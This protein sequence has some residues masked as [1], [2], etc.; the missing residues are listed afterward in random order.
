MKRSTASQASAT[1]PRTPSGVRRG[2]GL[3]T[4]LLAATTGLAACSTGAAGPPSDAQTDKLEVISWWTSGSEHPALQSLFDAFTAANPGVTITDGAVAGGGGSNVAVVLA[5]RLTAG[6]PPD[7]WQT[8]IGASTK[9]YANTGRIADVSSVYA[10]TGLAGAIPKAILDSV[11][12]GGKQYSVPSGSHRS[13]VLWFNRAALA[14]AGVSVPTTGYTTDAWTADLGKL[15]AAGVVPLCLGGQDRFASAELF[16]SIL[17]GAIGPEGWSA[18]AADRFDWNGAKANSALKQFGKVL[19]YA[20]P[21]AGGLTWDQA[22]KK[23]GSGECAFESFNDSAYGEL[24]K[25][26]A[27]EGTDFGYVPMPGTEGSYLA[28]VDAFVVAAGAK[29]GRNALAFLKIVADKTETVAFN[30]LK[31]SVPLRGDV[32]TASLSP[33]QKQALASLSKDTLLLSIVHGE[34][35]SPA[36]QSAFYDAVAAFAG[37]RDPATFGKTLLSSLSVP[38]PGGH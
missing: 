38:I 15:K 37:S 23:L 22:T 31:G 13:N 20:D 30:K 5:S 7:V 34:L 25:A 32:D 10:D 28:V 3:L 2:P 24:V 35:V 16:E 17:L 8:F 11:T 9:A 18:I 6:D 19:D 12:V 4:A 14:K 29:N 33:Y 26:G 1:Q 21:Q 36:Y 27:A